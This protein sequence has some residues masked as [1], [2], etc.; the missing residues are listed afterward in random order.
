MSPKNSLA[1]D[2]LRWS[3]IFEKKRKRKGKK[4]GEKEEKKREGRIM[5]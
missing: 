1:Y 5:S 3:R 2:F 4:E